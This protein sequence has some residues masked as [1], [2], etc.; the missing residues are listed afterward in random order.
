MSSRSRSRAIKKEMDALPWSHARR[1]QLMSDWQNASTA[2]E[3]KRGWREHYGPLPEWVERDLKNYAEVRAAAQLAR[4][5]KRF[6]HDKKWQ[7]VHDDLVAEH[8][9]RVAAG[10]YSSV[11]RKEEPIIS[12]AAYLLAHR[13]ARGDLKAGR[14]ANVNADRA[15]RAARKSFEDLAARKASVEFLNAEIIERRL[16]NPAIRNSH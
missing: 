6:A 16:K 4:A 3:V 12:G 7:I 2:S 10:E 8:E 5:A 14:E 1:F 9:A 15:Y 13:A 11:R